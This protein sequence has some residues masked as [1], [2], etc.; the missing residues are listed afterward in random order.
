[1]KNWWHIKTLVTVFLN[2]FYGLSNQNRRP[3]ATHSSW[4]V[5]NLRSL[6]RHGKF[7]WRHYEW[8]FF[9]FFHNISAYSTSW[10]SKRF[11]FCAGVYSLLGF[12][13]FWLCLGNYSDFVDGGNV[14][15]DCVM[16]VV[17]SVNGGCCRFGVGVLV[18]WM[19]LGDGRRVVVPAWL[20]LRDEWCCVV[21]EEFCTFLLFLRI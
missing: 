1:M 3:L 21:A 16:V 17:F 5:S 20:C 7:I 14:H 15:M 19:V 9:V 12:Q 10:I 18:R 11:H 2:N 8:P 6:S 4:D 13:C